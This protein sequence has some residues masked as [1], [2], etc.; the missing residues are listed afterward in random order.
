[1]T[2]A[3][4]EGNAYLQVLLQHLDSGERARRI[5]CDLTAL[6]TRSDGGDDTT[7]FERLRFWSVLIAYLLGA[8]ES[9]VGPDGREAIVQTMRNAGASSHLAQGR[10]Q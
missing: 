6:L 4:E 9:R 10:M 1:M 8:A 5:G 7:A 2:D 3:H